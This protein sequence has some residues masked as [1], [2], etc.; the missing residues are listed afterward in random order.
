[1]PRIQLWN[2]YKTNDYDFIDRATAEFINAGGTGVFVHKYIG[3]YQDDTS[4]S[5]GSDELYIPVSYT[6][7]TLPTKA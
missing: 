1:M 5:I 6:H 4:A 7:L 2:K 3:T